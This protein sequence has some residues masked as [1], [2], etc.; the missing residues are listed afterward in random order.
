MTDCEKRLAKTW[1][2]EEGIVVAEVARLLRRNRSFIWELLADELDER[3]RV[4]RKPSSTEADKD[5]L[6]ALTEKMVKRADV[7]WLVKAELI[8][9][10]L[11][12]KVCVRIVQDALHERGAWFHRLREKSARETT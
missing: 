10:K 7:R 3:Y 1:A 8:R 6:V 2:K 11:A 12:P 4:G 5:L 9:K